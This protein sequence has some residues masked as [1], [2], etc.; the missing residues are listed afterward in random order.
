VTALDRIWVWYLATAAGVGT[1]SAGAPQVGHR[2][3]HHV[4]LHSGLLLVLLAGAAIERRRG[5]GGRRLWRSLFT[6]VAL[7]AVYT[8]I[9]WILPGAH[10]EA[11]EWLWI[12]LDRA[13]FGCDPT[14][15]A[16]AVLS[17][18]LVETLQLCY[19]TFYFLPIAVLVA[20]AARGDR[21]DFD[22]GLC[23]VTFGFL[24]SYQLY[25]LF[26]TLPPY[27]Y[28]VHDQPLA[29]VWIA[30]P[31]HALLDRLEG[32][33]FDCFPSGHTWVTL[34]T[35]AVAWRSAR[36]A[37]WVVLPIATLLIASTVALR[38]HYAVDVAAGA[39]LAPVSQRVVRWL[40]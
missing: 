24:C 18:P 34:V 38:Y 19:A 27:R 39:A 3:L 32:N 23:A 9:G 29:G 15:A 4:L 37:F 20:V 21:E 33:R 31:L 5:G 6:L 28:L 16:Q 11:Y 2:P 40:L 36:A 12:A 26:P 1:L 8:S 10:P 17:P 13:L 35:L 25:V 14:V 30:E 22:R 7:P